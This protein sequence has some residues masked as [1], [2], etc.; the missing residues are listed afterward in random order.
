MD[1]FAQFMVLVQYGMVLIL[2]S[3]QGNY[4][5]T[6]IISFFV[7]SIWEYFVGWLLEKL[8]HVKY[9]GY[10]YY[11]FNIKG[12]ICLV[13]S[14]TWGFLGVAFTE[15]IHPITLHIFYKIPANIINWITL[16]LSV[17]TIIDFWATVIK[18]KNIT[19]SIKKLSEITSSIK[20]KLEELKNLPEK[21]KKSEK[22][23]SAIE[24][25]RQKQAEI[26]E[27]LEK[28]TQRL[29]KAFPNIRS[30]RKKE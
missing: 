28:Q 11:K 21:A 10:S 15:L 22:L 2:N 12:R 3:F 18:I 4:I 25:L 27:K 30:W 1:H 24:E 5:A 14:L 7:F 26:K 20:E 13:N 16:L 29:R 6:F 8:F 23:N 19:L 9:W 17:Y